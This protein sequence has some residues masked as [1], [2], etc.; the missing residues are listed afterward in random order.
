MPGGESIKIPASLQVNASEL[1]GV[2]NKLQAG[3]AK[4]KPDSK[5]YAQ[6]N[7][8]LIKL[9]ARMDAITA[10]MRQGF[11]NP[12]QLNKFEQKVR[13]LG[14]GLQTMAM[15]L[16]RITF[17]DLN[18]D[19]IPQEQ[20]DRLKELQTA[21]TEAQ[22]K[23]DGFQTTQMREVVKE[24][25]QL[26][27]AF[28]DLKLDI[29]TSSFDKTLKEAEKKIQTL[30][31]S[32]AKSQ[33]K[34]ATKR[35]AVQ[36]AQALLK[37]GDELKNI[38][39]GDASKRTDTR[40]FKAN[41]DYAAGGRDAFIKQLREIG[42]DKETLEAIGNESARN[43]D[44]FWEKIQQ[45]LQKGNL[46]FNLK[47]NVQ[48]AKAE[49]QQA[50]VEQVSSQQAVTDVEQLLNLLHELQNVDVGGTRFHEIFAQLQSGLRQTATEAENYKKQIKDAA[51]PSE[52]MEKTVTYLTQRVKE[53]EA[54]LES[55]SSGM[56]ASAAA[57]HEME[58][59]QQ[60]L[61]MAIRQ[62]FSFREVI[63]LTKR[64]I[65]DAVAHIKELDA[66]MTQI[67]VVTNMSQKDLWGQI[68]TYSAI[69]Q[70]YGVSTN[71]VYQ[72]SQLFYQQGLQTADVM[73]LTTETLKMAKI[74][75]LDYATATDYMTVAI[76]G[77]KLEMDD[78]QH[79]TDVYSHIAAISASDTEELAVAM[80]KTAS[81]AEAVGSSFENTTAMIALM[82]D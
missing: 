4:V 3:M 14:T 33:T 49:L 70:Q 52:G 61:S 27:A 65:S 80:S 81:S 28:A 62:W 47:E 75:N 71:G 64:A 5:A 57:T 53:L 1:Q 6:L 35:Q 9:Q 59:S 29:D 31:E 54:K 36:D 37:T 42:I 34:V 79:V 55:M 76:R 40:F 23:V 8:E 69:A 72:V 39:S 16:S 17:E 2:I 24:S 56:R 11:Q 22:A 38:F 58:A 48:K 13:T 18:T 19:I 15:H 68:G 20:L 46:L 50:Q 51:I 63:N 7:T 25:E 30:R 67:A 60:R 43:I 74:A 44:Q 82:V 78:A 41:G 12:S 45:A 10:D 21:L 66:T 73:K 77:F 32:A 26:K